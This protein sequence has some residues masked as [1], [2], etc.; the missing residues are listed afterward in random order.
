MGVSAKVVL[1]S[2]GWPEAKRLKNLAQEV[3]SLRFEFGQTNE[4]CERLLA[5]RTECAWRT[6]VGR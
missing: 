4:R 6:Q 1:V 5:A 2:W 3:M